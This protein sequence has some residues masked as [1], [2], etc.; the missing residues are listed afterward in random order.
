[1]FPT[2]VTVFG[3]LTSVKNIFLSY[4]NNLSAIDKQVTNDLYIYFTEKIGDQE[5]FQVELKY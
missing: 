3:I 2:N 1:M 4:Y 5:I